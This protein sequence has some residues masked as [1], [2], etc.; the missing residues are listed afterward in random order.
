MNRSLAAYLTLQLIAPLFLMHYSCTSPTDTPEEQESWSSA[1]PLSVNHRVRQQKYSQGN[2][3]HNPSFEIGKVKQVDSLTQS[4]VIEG[5]DYV[6]QN[7]RWIKIKTDSVSTASPY[8]NSGNRSIKII[9]K[10]ASETD[11]LGDGVISDYIRVI[12]GNYNLSMYLNL[13]DIENPKSRL[14]M[15]I[16]DAV[17]IRLIYYDRNK[18]TISGE[19]FSPYNKNYFNNSFK[20]ESL[21]KFDRI[22]STGWI[23]VQGRSHLFPFPDGDIQDDAKFVRI[24]IGLKGNGTMYIDDIDYT[25]T[26]WNFTQLERLEPYFDTSFSLGQLIIPQPRSVE[27]MESIIYYRPYYKEVFPVV[28]IPQESDKI[29]IHAAKQLEKHIR[30]T[31]SVLTNTELDAIPGLITKNITDRIRQSTITF[32]IGNTDLFKDVRNTTPMDQI[33]NKE[34]GFIVHTLKEDLGVIYLNGNSPL[35][36][37]YAVQAAIQL[38]DNRRLLFHNANIIDYPENNVRPLLLSGLD[39]YGMEFLKTTEA[40]RYNQIY[41]PSS[42][43]GLEGKIRQLNNQGNYSI[44]LYSNLESDSEDPYLSEGSISSL[45]IENYSFIDGY[46]LINESMGGNSYSNPDNSG[47]IQ[48]N[49][50]LRKLLLSGFSF[51]IQSN[52]SRSGKSC[53]ELFSGTIQNPKAFENVSHIWTGNGNYSWKLDE[54]D[55]LYNTLNVLGNKVFMDM[56]LFPGDHTSGYFMYDSLWPYKL[57]K[58]SLFE[59]YNNE[60]VSEIYQKTDKTIIA[61]RADNIFDEIRLQTASDYLWN[62]DSYN[63]DL[64]LY[65]ALTTTFGGKKA[66][67]LLHFNDLYFKVR[68]EIIL[69]STLKSYQK[70]LRKSDVYIEEMKRLQNSFVEEGERKKEK[71]LMERIDDLVNEIEILRER[72]DASSPVLE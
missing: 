5:W 16:Y 68:S 14:G 6:G 70:H 13:V 37:F 21:S 32:S 65:L 40:T 71:E 49:N 19:K 44:R 2:L 18:L 60:V 20:S 25:Y 51:E 23:H 59:P 8:I 45:L 29:T 30:Q 52:N 3:V 47:E 12:P 54:A 69:A 48:F 36:T 10:N 15:G 7:I 24:L 56:T 9:R 31:I 63:P 17:D 27:I 34:Q 33:E 43:K 22:D 35:S 4:V 57:A 11:K 66:K 67:N 53:A 72:Q 38:F 55:Y 58:A 50:S 42:T 26:R 62:P 61:F 28:L 41:L 1:D 39:E 46:A 64:S